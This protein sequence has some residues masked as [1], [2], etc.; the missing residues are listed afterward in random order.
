MIWIPV[1]EQLPP[2]ERTLSIDV[3]CFLE[4]EEMMVTY[5]NYASGKWELNNSKNSITH[6]MHLPKYPGA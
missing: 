5:Y 4:D 6:W 1:N 3:L 2:K